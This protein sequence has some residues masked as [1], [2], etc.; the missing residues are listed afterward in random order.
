MIRFIGG[1]LDGQQRDLTRHPGR[2]YLN[3]YTVKSVLMADYGACERP[4]G[5]DRYYL[6]EREE[7]VY[8]LMEESDGH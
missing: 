5:C 8:R 6:D 7:P 3:G 4:L 2:L 1:I